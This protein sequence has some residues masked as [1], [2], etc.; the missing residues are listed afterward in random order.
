MNQQERQE[1]SKASI[2]QAALEEFAANGYGNVNMERICANHH[3]SKGM[4]YHYYSSKDELFL[5]CVEKTFTDLKAYIEN[6]TE[7][8]NSMEILDAIKEY[9]AIREQFFQLN[10]KQKEIFETALFRPPKHLAESIQELRQP[11]KTM[12]MEFMENLVS[13]MPLRPGLSKEKALRYLE[14]IEVLF[15]YYDEKR[16]QNLHSMLKTIGEL[17]DMALFGILKQGGNDLRR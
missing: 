4:M 12:N 7:R 3:I 14:S 13:R 2:Y 9:F 15:R 10:P 6:Q 1:R 8:M 5:L 16:E 17:M 11:I